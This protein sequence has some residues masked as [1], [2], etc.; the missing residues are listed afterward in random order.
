MPI[1]LTKSLIAKQKESKLSAE[2]LAKA[3]GV[4]TVSLRGVLRGKSK[5]NATTAKKYAEFLGLD[6]AALK[7]GG[8]TAR[9]APRKAKRGEKAAARPA[10]SASRSNGLGAELVSAVAIAAAILD[11]TI[12]LAVHRAGTAERELIGRL[13]GVK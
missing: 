7:G 12:A 6:P 5:P 4:S 3:I 10:R 1:N 9:K 11:D 13:L 2:A 8:K